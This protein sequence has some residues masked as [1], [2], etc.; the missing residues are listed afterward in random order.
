MSESKM[1][2]MNYEML[3]LLISKIFIFLQRVKKFSRDTGSAMFQTFNVC[4]TLLRLALRHCSNNI[5]FAFC[6]NKIDYP[7]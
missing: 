2:F 6:C 7:N 4:A 3:P 1:E 5:I